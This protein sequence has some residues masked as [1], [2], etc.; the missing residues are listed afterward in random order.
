[1]KRNDIKK[2]AENNLPELA[3][4]LEELQMNLAKTRLEKKAGKLENTALLRIYADDIARIKT[5]MTEKKL[6][7][8]VDPKTEIK[9]KPVASQSKSK[10]KLTSK[11]KVKKESKSKN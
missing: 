1:M 11:M 6:S 3:K 8:K 10:K 9:K 7:I 2:L 5:V 4:L